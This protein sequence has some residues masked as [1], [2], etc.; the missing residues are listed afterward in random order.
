[1]N[2]RLVSSLMVAALAASCDQSPPP[3]RKAAPAALAA[4]PDLYKVPLGD[5]PVR[6]PADAK[7]TVVVFSDFECPFCAR[8]ETTLDQIRGSFGDDVRVVWKHLPLPFHERALPAALA[9]EAARDQ[10]RFWEMHDQLFAHREALGEAELEARARALGLD[11]ERFRASLAAPATR[12]RIEADLRLADS[13]GVHGTP[14]SFVNGRLLVG[15]QPLGAFKP[16]LDQE[17]ARATARLKG[18]V[19][20]GALYAALVE[21]GLDK[22]AAPPAAPAAQGCHAPGCAGHGP[23]AP[24]DTTTVFKVDPGTSPARGPA[25]APVTV[26]LF[27]DLQCPFCKKV[28]PTLEALEKAY[29]G[30]VRVVWK[31]FPL[32]FHPAARL[33]AAAAMAAHAEGKFWP[34]HDRLLA[35][36]AALDRTTIEGY[37]RELGL[38]RGRFEAAL[39]GGDALLAP[40]LKQAAA[41]GVTGTPTVF[42]NG[43]R[44]TGAY[45]LATFKELVD[46]EL[47][48]VGGNR[49]APL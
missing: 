34:M 42:V 16:I 39:D 18:G 13:L 21:G 26:V 6:G 5:S 7:L 24:E 41:L 10:G 27:S 25:G 36:G 30:K 28:E 47:A 14:S 12:A 15:A 35:G 49:A 48:K 32:D 37:A 38:D 4:T 23:G 8:F 43:R 2:T 1:M 29:P 46:Q 20:R 40:D 45:P 31:N 11:L 44:V 3:D 22:V 19:G 17:L 9:A 33:A